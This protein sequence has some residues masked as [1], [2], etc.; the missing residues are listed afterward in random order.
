MEVAEILMRRVKDPRLDAVTVTD[1][2]MTS[3][4]RMARVYVTT[5]QPDQDEAL[6]LA[7][8][9]RAAG[10]VRAEL[11][12]RLQLRYT[13][14]VSFHLDVSGPRGDAILKLLD[15]VRPEAPE[16]AGGDERLQKGR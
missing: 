14:E 1:V 10:F 16:D 8:L 4:L 11:G 5:L 12:R 3:D 2:E 7:S 15:T 6:L 9:E 13:P